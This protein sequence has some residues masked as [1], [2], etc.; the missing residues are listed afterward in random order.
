MKLKL[1]LDQTK[2]NILTE[3]NDQVNGFKSKILQI[4]NELLESNV[5]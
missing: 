2:E 3:R 5:I 4:E 1:E